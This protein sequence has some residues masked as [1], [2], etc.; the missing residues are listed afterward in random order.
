LTKDDG[1]RDYQESFSGQINLPEDDPNIFER[2]VQFLYCGG[3]VDNV[4]QTQVNDDEDVMVPAMMR[5]VDVESE[6]QPGKRFH[7]RSSL[8]SVEE[9]AR[10]F[11]KPWSTDIYEIATEIGRSDLEDL[12]DGALTSARVY[13][14]ADKFLVPSL[15]L[16]ALD[17]LS[18][19]FDHIVGHKT[20]PEWIETVSEIYS[21]APPDLILQELCVAYINQQYDEFEEQG[22]LD[23]ISEALSVGLGHFL[24]LTRHY[25][26]DDVGI[27]QLWV[28]RMRGTGNSN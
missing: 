17:R 3:Y 5:G 23:K 24:I 15:K 21:I 10:D 4:I 28:Q 6:L 26:S 7:W 27:R 12:A 9:Y 25:E 22:D 16:L 20:A 14:M 11:P 8:E 13:A 19:I 1:F 2:F 18:L